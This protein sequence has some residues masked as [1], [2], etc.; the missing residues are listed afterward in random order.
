MTV[1]RELSPKAFRLLSTSAAYGVFGLY[2]LLIGT[3]FYY[4]QPDELFATLRSDRFAFSLRLSLFAAT[5]ATL[6]SLF[7]GVPAAYAL[8]RYRFFGQR[9]VDTML[10]LP[11]V[12]SPAA[13]GAALLIFFAQPGGQWLQSQTT[14]FVFAVPGIIAAQ[15]VTTLGIATRLL[16]A[17][18][19]EIPRR[20]E[21]M[22]RCLG[23]SPRKAFVTVTL[24]L[25][26]RGIL[27]AA[28]LTWAKALGEFGA[29]I[30]VAGTMAMKTETLPVSI[31]MR[32]SS[33]DIGGTVALILLLVAIG[34]S[35]LYLVRVV[36]RESIRA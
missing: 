9:L 4:F 33:A 26:R 13:L 28:V 17:A 2:A 18:F 24:P 29:T 19:S 25:A 31:Y 32:L 22:A 14:Y 11:M 3:L 36:L 35:A 15:F 16:A 27:G 21:D 8:V 10:E 1:H 7:F 20:Y 6:L 30:T 5:S 34:L 12:V 23:A